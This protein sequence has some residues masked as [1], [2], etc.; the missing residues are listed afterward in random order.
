MGAVAVRGARRRWLM[1]AVAAAGLTASV[2]LGAAVA[3]ASELVYWDN[4]SSSAS[5]IGVADVNSGAATLLNAAGAELDAPEGMSYDPVTNRLYVANEASAG[6]TG[7]ISYVNLDG[8]GGGVFPVPA[9]VTVVDPSGL[10]IDPT[11]RIVYW[12]NSAP[13]SISWARL[14]GSEGGTVTT[15]RRRYWPRSD[16]RSTGWPAGSTGGTTTGRSASRRSSAAAVPPA[17]SKQRGPV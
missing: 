5:S 6:G 15:G 14:D 12:L 9:G 17:R 8:S 13:E 11:T 16:W 7:Q 2:L 3:D 10:V 4:N 1:G